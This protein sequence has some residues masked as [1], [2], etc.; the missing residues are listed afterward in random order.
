MKIFQSIDLD[1][2][3]IPKFGP[4]ES[5]TD[6]N[7]YYNTREHVNEFTFKFWDQ[8]DKKI[9]SVSK[10]YEQRENLIMLSKRLFIQVYNKV[11]N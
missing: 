1:I 10:I 2:S 5:V 3:K 4:N 9:S 6:I 8:I 7:N 11:N